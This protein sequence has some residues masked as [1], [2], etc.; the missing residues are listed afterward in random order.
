MFFLEGVAVGA[1]VCGLL[2]EASLEGVV[3]GAVVGGFMLGSMA[4][5]FLGALTAARLLTGRRNRCFFGAMV[6]FL[7]FL[8]RSDP[9]P[10]NGDLE[11]TPR[12]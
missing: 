12:R 10:L 8:A 5:A 1:V 3:V 2:A 6:D 11:T 7:A 9:E 4:E